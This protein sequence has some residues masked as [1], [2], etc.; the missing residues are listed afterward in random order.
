[1]QTLFYTCIFTISLLSC[2]SKPSDYEKTITDY[3]ETRNGVKTDLQIKYLKLD[4]SDISVGDSISILNENFE[5]EK[6]KKI[7]SIEQTIKHKEKAIAEQNEKLATAKDDDK[8]VAKSLISMWEKELQKEKEY[9]DETQK[10]KPDYLN[11]YTN[12]NP[13]DILAKKVDITISYFNPRLQI[14]QEMS[15][16]TILSLDGKQ[17]YGTI[18]K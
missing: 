12:R 17:C 3:L 18:K 15:M 10:W 11:K 2:S 1:M 4:V 16:L 7:Q 9:L 8:V 13:S 5:I 14:R 6:R